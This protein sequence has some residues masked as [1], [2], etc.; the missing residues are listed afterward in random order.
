MLNLGGRLRRVLGATVIPILPPVAVGMAGVVMRQYRT[1]G[2]GGFA[3]ETIFVVSGSKVD[4]P[5]WV[6]DFNSFRR[7]L[8]SED[9]PDEGRICFINGKVWVDLSTERF[10]DHGQVKTEITRVLATLMKQT[11][12]GRFAP[13]GTRYSHLESRLSTEPDGL[14]IAN[15]SFATKRVEL[16]SGKKGKDT[17]LIGTPDIVIEIVSPDSEDKDTEWLMAAYHN[18]GIPEYWLIDAREEDDTRFDVYKRGPKEYKASRKSDGWVK[19]PTLGKS[20]RLVP[21]E[22]E[23][24]N[25]EFPLEVR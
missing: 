13:D 18:A 3:V 21:G 8:H 12:F 15:A 20:F 23:N 4:K 7:W 9:F 24:G 1:T 14:V 11:R 22:D 17:E 2:S 10:F 19:S 6:V 25:P 16:V 5:A